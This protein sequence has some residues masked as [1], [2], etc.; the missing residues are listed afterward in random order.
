MNPLVSII[1]PAYNRA[2]LI[3]DTLDSISKQTYVNWECIV[4]DDGST[5]STIDVVMSFVEKDSRFQLHHR[6]NSKLK[7]A[8]ACRNY[9]FE[10]SKGDYVN[11]FD[12]D[13]LMMPE[14]VATQI[15][16]LHNSSY[17]F[18]LCQ[19]MMYDVKKGRE[20]GLRSTRLR[21]ENIFEDYIL[22]K[23]FWLI[24]APIWRRGFLIE[25]KIFFDEELQQAQ[26]YDF[27]M[28]VLSVSDNYFSN[29]TP[30]VLVKCHENNMSNSTSDRPSKVFSN[31]KV[32]NNILTVYR[33]KLSSETLKVNYA[34]LLNLYKF[35]LRNKQF[36]N[37]LY[38][39]KCLYRNV[40]VLEIS[41]SKKIIFLA[42]VYM[43]FLIF[44]VFSKGDVFL[45]FNI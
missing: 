34:Y 33:T 20:I 5:D 40:R 42:Q 44:S 45:K 17:D 41:N 30:F 11:W 31:A 25:N 7:G 23:T 43:S 36:K 4:V 12:S 19:S 15:Q 26:D 22:F 8:N 9:G 16:E 24:E 27:H 6:P 3:G 37:S 38:I 13:D 39:I 35:S 28:K 2:Q 18:T 10:I 1:I 32:K 29:N 14:K 21:S